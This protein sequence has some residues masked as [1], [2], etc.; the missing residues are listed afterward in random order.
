MQ[1]DIWRVR[2][3]IEANKHISFIDHRV[4]VTYHIRK[5]STVD[6][7]CSL[8]YGRYHYRTNGDGHNEKGTVHFSP[9]LIPTNESN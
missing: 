1:Y 8:E 4:S 9:K 6:N 3:V 2:L 7:P 5:P